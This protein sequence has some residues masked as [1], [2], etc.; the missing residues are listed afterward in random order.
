GEVAGAFAGVAYRAVAADQLDGMREVFV[1]GA[2]AG[3]GFFPE[4][5][6]LA[7][8]ARIGEDRRQGHLAFA[9]I[10][11]AVLAHVGGAAVVVD[12]VV[13]QLE[14]DAEVAAVVVERALLGLAA[15]GDDRGDAA[16]GGEQRGGLG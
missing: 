1:L 14:G 16:G 11:A 10:V 6:L 2:E 3:D 9:E 15:F 13:D 12:R 8:P 4:L 5:A 7:R